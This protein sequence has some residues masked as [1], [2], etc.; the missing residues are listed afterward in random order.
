MAIAISDQQ[1]FEYGKHFGKTREAN[2]VAGTG[3]SSPTYM[4][5][6][7]RIFQDNI[8]FTEDL[9]VDSILF[10]WKFPVDALILKGGL[11]INTAVGGSQEITT[12]IY[13]GVQPDDNLVGSLIWSWPTDSTGAT[14][15]LDRNKSHI[16]DKGNVIG[17]RAN[18]P[19]ILTGVELTYYFMYMSIL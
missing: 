17:F 3:L 7:V 2:L 14:D 8:S 19:S 6:T 15:D 11:Y 4:N 12:N 18:P 9:P 10:G 5:G 13:T 16:V 1:S